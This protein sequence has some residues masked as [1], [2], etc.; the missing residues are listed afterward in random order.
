MAGAALANPANGADAEAPSAGDPLDQLEGK[1]LAQIERLVI[2]RTIAR[3]DGS[4]ARAARELGL[5]PSTI[6]RKREAWS[7]EGAP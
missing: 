1:T 6:Y 7:A 5:S 2:E 3:H 4:V